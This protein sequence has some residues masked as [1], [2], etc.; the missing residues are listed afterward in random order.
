M[1]VNKENP[2]KSVNSLEEQQAE[3]GIVGYPRFEREWDK[4][5]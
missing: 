5:V 4:T 2:N 1:D 3:V